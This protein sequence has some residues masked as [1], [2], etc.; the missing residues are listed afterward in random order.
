MGGIH[1]MRGVGGI[2][3]G[4]G[5]WIIEGAIIISES[6]PYRIAASYYIG[7]QT[8]IL[9]HIRTVKAWVIDLT[10]CIAGCVCCSVP[11]FAIV[12]TSRYSSYIIGWYWSAVR[13]WLV[14]NEIRR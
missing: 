10:G 14:R 8:D 9:I 11:G 7:G 12:D 2:Y 6:G 1:V 4:L 3:P 5:F 13:F